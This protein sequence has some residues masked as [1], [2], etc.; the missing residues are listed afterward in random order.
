MVPSRGLSRAKPE[1][2]VRY[3]IGGD[4]SRGV[5]GLEY[6]RWFWWRI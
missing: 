3:D 2:G 5:R 6:I 1:I 4:I